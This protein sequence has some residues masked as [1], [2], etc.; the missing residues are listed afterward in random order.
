MSSDVSRQDKLS[1]PLIVDTSLAPDNGDLDF[2]IN[3]RLRLDEVV[4]VEEVELRRTRPNGP[5][6]KQLCQLACQ[7]YDARRARNRVLGSDLFGEPAWD[8][9]L[10]L[11]CCPARGEALTVTSL[12]LAAEIKPTTG[13]RW[14]E[15]LTEKG[16]IKRGPSRDGDAR[17]VHVALTK[18]G[19][20]LMEG[21]LTRLFFCSTPVPAHSDVHDD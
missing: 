20:D 14:Q 17:R 9:L 4:N 8:I 1:V 18:D 3:L 10:A 12:S 13:H 16:L 7:I 21:Y 19:R 6:R 11:Y 15:Y 5:T 2:E